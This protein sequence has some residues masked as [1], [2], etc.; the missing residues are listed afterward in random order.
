MK[1]LLLIIGLAVLVFVLGFK[2]GR[3]PKA[4]EVQRRPEAEPSKDMVACAQCGLHLPRDEALPGRGGHFCSAS[5]RNAYES[6]HA[7]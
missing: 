2:R 7:P 3:P 4:S 6:S 5:H 1:Y